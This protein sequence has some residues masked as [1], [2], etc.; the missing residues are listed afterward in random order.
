M[1]EAN[2]WDDASI[3]IHLR[4]SLKDEVRECGR[5]QTIPG[6]EARLGGRFGI[7]PLEA[8]A[9]LA[10][11]KKHHK[12]SL[13]QHADEIS[14]LIMLG[15]VELENAQQRN[16]AMESF[17]NSLGNP[18]LQRH[19]LAIAPADLPT[20]V[21]ACT[22][23]LNICATGASNV[24]QLGEED[25]AYVRALS[26]KDRDTLDNLAKIVHEPSNSVAGLQKENLELKQSRRAGAGKKT[27][28]NKGKLV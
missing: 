13:Q 16:L 20:A 1:A 18:Q 27:E 22:E 24:R 11:L 6:I 4:E 19:L 2:Y 17:A 10:T 21:Q 28:Y 15:Y 3:L 23:Y 7:T 25:T 14:N 12:T 8:R 9:K 5:S 26:G